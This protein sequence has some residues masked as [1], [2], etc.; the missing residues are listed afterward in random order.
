[1]ARPSAH[2]GQLARA[3][4]PTSFP[5]RPECTQPAEALYALS[6]SSVA[7][8]VFLV[9]LGTVGSM[10]PV[11]AIARFVEGLSEDVEYV[12][13]GLGLGRGVTHAAVYF[14]GARRL[15]AKRPEASPDPGDE[16]LQPPH[17]KVA[18]LQGRQVSTGEQVESAVVSGRR[19]S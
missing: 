10:F 7:F 1:M 15:L 13:G 18:W 9:F 19:A 11:R 6:R 3:A 16:E 2:L 5:H 8:G 14:S 4:P 17:S 12:D